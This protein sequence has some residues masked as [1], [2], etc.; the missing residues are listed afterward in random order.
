[1]PRRHRFCDLGPVWIQRTKTKVSS[2][3]RLTP[4]SIPAARASSTTSLT[5]ACRT[6]M[7]SAAGMLRIQRSFRMMLRI[8]HILPNGRWWLGMIGAENGSH[9]RMARKRSRPQKFKTVTIR[10]IDSPL[11]TR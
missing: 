10:G 8:R 2:F 7:G 6:P 5:T 11:W 3:R 9:S 1:V 4:P